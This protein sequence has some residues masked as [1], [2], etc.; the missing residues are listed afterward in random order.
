M[1]RSVT[2]SLLFTILFL[3]AFSALSPHPRGS[4]LY[5]GVSQPVTW[6]VK[7]KDICP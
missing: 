6:R 3:S 4:P 1:R 5:L 7:E 2:V